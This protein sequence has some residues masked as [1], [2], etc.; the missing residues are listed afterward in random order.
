MDSLKKVVLDHGEL[1]ENR[2]AV[3]GTI[4][5]ALERCFGLLPQAKGF[6]IQTIYISQAIPDGRLQKPITFTSKAPCILFITHDFKK[7]NLPFI[8]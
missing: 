2:L 1:Q 3:D 5:H 4:L 6:T 8:S 7:F